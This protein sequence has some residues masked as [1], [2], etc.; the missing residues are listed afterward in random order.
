MTSIQAFFETKA[1]SSLPVSPITSVSQ[2]NETSGTFSSTE[3]KTASSADLND[4]KPRIDYEEKDI[5]TLVPGPESVT[6][7]ARIANLYHRLTPRTPHRAKSYWKVIVKDDSGALAVRLWYNKVN[8]DLCLGHLVSVWTTCVSNAEPS[9]PMLRSSLFI[10]TIF[11]ERDKRCYFMVQEQIDEGVLYKTPQSYRDGMQLPGLL[12]LKKFINGGHKSDGCKVLLCVKNSGAVTVPNGVQTGKIDVQVF[13][14]TANATLTLWGSTASAQLIAIVFNADEA[15]QAEV[16][17][18]FTLA[19]IDEFTVRQGN[20]T[21]S[22]SSTKQL[23]ERFT[24]YLSLLIVELNIHTL[25]RRG[26]LFCN[27]CCGVP[28]YANMIHRKCKQCE[29]DVI[30]RINPRLI[31]LL[32]DETGAIACSKLIWSDEAWEQL[33]GR[34]AEELAVTTSN[35]NLLKYLDHRLLFLRLAILFGWSHEVGKLVILRVGIV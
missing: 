33:L 6:I 11:P 4:W 12:T 3:T 24:G 1:P 15:A 27:Q 20:S 10:T 2:K 7:T 21:T 28:V 23:T 17:I 30:L 8:Y 29:K 25:Y 9:S 13:D 26:R 32:I 5:G 35:T 34:N 16:R 31:G 22:S 14:D 19:E 18:L